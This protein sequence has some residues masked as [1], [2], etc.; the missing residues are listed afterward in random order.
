MREADG[1]ATKMGQLRDIC[2]TR[3]DAFQDVRQFDKLNDFVQGYYQDRFDFTS[4]T[5][6]PIAQ[7]ARITEARITKVTDREVT[8]DVRTTPAVPPRSWYRDPLNITGHAEAG[9]TVE[10]YNASQPGRPVIGDMQADSNGKFRFEL[11]DETLFNYGDQIGIRVRDASGDASEAV[12]VPT[13]PFRLD[14]LT[15]H[16]RQGSTIIRTDNTATLTALNPNHDTRNPFFQQDKVDLTFTPPATHDAPHVLEFI[17]KDDSVE[18][19]STLTVKVGNEEY[20]TKADKFGKFGLKVFG[21]QPGDHLKLE[22]KDVNG[23]GIDMNYQVPTVTLNMQELAN[24]ITRPPSSRRPSGMDQVVGEGPPWVKINAPQVTVPHGAVMIKNKTTDEVFEIKA[25]ENGDISAALGGIDNFDVLEMAARDAK[26]NLSETAEVAVMLPEKVRRFGS[27]LVPAEAMNQAQ[28]NIASVL[29]AIEGPPQDVEVNGT[30]MPGG[31]FLGMPDIAGMPPFGQLAVIKEG[32]VVQYMRADK[33]GKLEGLLRGVHVGDQLNFQVLDAAGRKFP[34]EL[35]GWTVPGPGQ[36]NEVP[37]HHITQEDRT[38]E[39]ALEEIGK[40]TLD[41]IDPW[42]TNFEIKTGTNALPATSVPL[43]YSR[44]F[45]GNDA[46]AN[47]NEAKFDYFPPAV[48]EKMGML[49]SLGGAGQMSD[50]TLSMTENAGTKT[51]SLA[52]MRNGSSNLRRHSIGVDYVMGR[53]NR[54]Q[55]NSHFQIPQHLEELTQGLQAA[56]AFVGAAYVQGKEPGNMEY[57]RAMGAVKTYLYVFDR[58]AVDNPAEADAIKDAA[59]AAFPDGGFPFEMLNRFQVPPEGHDASDLLERGKAGAGAMSVM[60]AR[61]SAMG[62]LGVSSVGQADPG[63][64]MAPTVESA[65]I[66]VKNPSERG[67]TY[68]EPLR[69]RGRATP[70]DIVQIYNMS[71][72]NK[73]LLAE[74]VVG[75]DGTYDIVNGARDL[76]MGDQLGIMSVTQ[77]G[78]KSPM[79]VAP[80]DSYFYNGHPA[81]AQP[82][83]R[84]ERPPFFKAGDTEMKNTSYDENGKVRDGGPFWQLTGEELSVEPFSSLTVTTRTPDGEEHVVKAKVDGE[85]RFDLE[86]AAAPRSNVSIMIA[87]KNGN[88]A[89]SQLRTPGLADSVQTGDALRDASNGVVTFHLDGGVEV[90]GVVVASS[91]ADSNSRVDDTIIEDSDRVDDFVDVRLNQRYSYTDDGG[92]AREKDI[93]FKLKIPAEFADDFV[94][95]YG[96]S[97]RLSSPSMESIN[98]PGN[99][100]IEMRMVGDAQILDRDFGMPNMGGDPDGAPT[101]SDSGSTP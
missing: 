46:D 62:K 73:T 81:N 66:L 67:G 41:L 76:K 10:F 79:M 97:I 13:E 31:P 24:G 2:E 82:V 59:K 39:S 47:K 95:L 14:R 101:D 70:G 8:R 32:K 19:N 4:N 21:F 16:W 78:K 50:A 58:L 61:L 27:F 85:G 38:L 74:A 52:F 54:G 87:D 89:G 37:A 77:D 7:P 65:T 40:G 6:N 75:P 25:N 45:F 20:T 72:A 15:T 88:R 42:L 80:T 22:I 64:R 68:S 48:L 92:T 96:D 99:P 49:Q 86:F 100:A 35:R 69:V 33:A 36:T 29:A 90:R 23:R 60:D 63:A 1:D 30:P 51:I 56:L 44:E 55:P 53:V 28:P 91:A 94:S 98:Y 5:S 84:D 11:T 17:G 12:V 3:Q 9:A 18:P 93:R 71:S 34:Q 83:N 43:E 57:D 26:G